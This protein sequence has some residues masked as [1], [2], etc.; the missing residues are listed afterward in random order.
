M[1]RIQCNAM[2]INAIL[3]PIGMNSTSVYSVLCSRS[4]VC[5]DGRDNGGNAST[6]RGLGV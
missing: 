6:K 5:E 4:L 1:T 2:Q 3:L